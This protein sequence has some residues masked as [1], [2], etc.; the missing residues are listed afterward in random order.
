MFN[1]AIT[2]G[3]NAMLEILGAPVISCDIPHLPGEP[4][5]PEVPP[6]LLRGALGDL[7]LTCGV[8]CSEVHNPLSGL[9]GGLFSHCIGYEI[10]CP[11]LR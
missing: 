9:R 10:F 11:S 8:W 1:C 6:P 7:T 4:S 3:V 5:P 2:N